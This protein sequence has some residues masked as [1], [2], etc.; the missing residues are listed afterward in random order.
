MRRRISSLALMLAFAT[1]VYA[2]NASQNS[3]YYYTGESGCDLSEVD[4]CPS[5]CNEEETACDPPHW[6]AIEPGMDS[7][8]TYD[9]VASVWIDW[10]FGSGTN[11]GYLLDESMMYSVECTVEG[12]CQCI[13]DDSGNPICKFFLMHSNSEYVLP[14][15]TGLPCSMEEDGMD[16]DDDGYGYDGWY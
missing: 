15:N 5:D 8:S 10:I 11:S 9:Q 14:L 13:L 7:N 12:D 6:V 2:Q 3:C 4:E 16:G 1:G